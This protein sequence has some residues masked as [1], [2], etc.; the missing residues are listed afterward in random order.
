MGN[1]SSLVKN[2]TALVFSET[3]LVTKR[4]YSRFSENEN[5]SAPFHFRDQSRKIREWSRQVP[6]TVPDKT[7]VLSFLPRLM[8]LN[9]IQD[10]DT[11]WQD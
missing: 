9:K 4:E 8:I 6:R 10:S 7:R 11:L 5:E 2:E 3:D 1:E